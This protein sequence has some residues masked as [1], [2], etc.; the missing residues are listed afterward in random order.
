MASKSVARVKL[1]WQKLAKHAM[2]DDA[3]RLNKLKAAFDS[4]GVKVSSL[5][6]SLPQID[7]S[8]Y[9]ATASDPKLVESIEKMYS[10]LKVERPKI[11][12]NRVEELNYHHKMDKRRFEKFVAF[13]KSYVHSAE[14][15]KNKF[16]KMIPVKDMTMEDYS[17]TFPHWSATLDTPPTVGFAYDRIPG[18]SREEAAAFAQPDPVPYATKQAWKDWEE[19]YKKWYQ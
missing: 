2:P 18:L 5:P 1:D 6:D 14:V 10:S 11:P 7:W 19:K 12:A 4:T 13:A 9:K 17:L 8:H 3:T 15:V 16:E